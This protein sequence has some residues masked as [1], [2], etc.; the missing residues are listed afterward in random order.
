MYGLIRFARFPALQGGGASR[1]L[2]NEALRIGSLHRTAN[3]KAR[4]GRDGSRNA[5]G[6][7]RSCADSGHTHPRLPTALRLTPVVTSDVVAEPVRTV[8]VSLPEKPAA[9]WEERCRSMLS[10][11]PAV[12][13]RFTPVRLIPVN[14]PPASRVTVP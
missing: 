11:A 6:S 1:R 7:R 5:T 13:P 3:P 4:C 12:T 8:W 9:Y 2:I 14:S 10:A